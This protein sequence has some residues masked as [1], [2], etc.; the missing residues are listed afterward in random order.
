MQRIPLNE[1]K[2]GMV[3]AEPLLYKNGMTLAGVGFELT[4]AALERFRQAGAAVVVVEGGDT[5]RYDELETIAVKLPFLFRRQTDNAFMMGMQG[6][7]AKHYAGKMAVL[8]AV[9]EEARLAKQAAV[10]AADE[11]AK[12]LGRDEA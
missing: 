4:E 2:P 1:A 9:D 11:A 3:L 10:P 6:I 5:G 7:L 8:K 12:A